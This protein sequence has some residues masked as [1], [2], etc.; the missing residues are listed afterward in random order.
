VRP[1][2]S[3]LAARVAK[4]ETKPSLIQR[5]RN[6]E[7]NLQSSRLQSYSQVLNPL[8]IVGA[9]ICLDIKRELATAVLWLLKQRCDLRLVR[10]GVE[11]VAVVA[12]L[13][14]QVWQGDV[15][16][17]H[18][19]DTHG[20]CHVAGV[21]CNHRRVGDDECTLRIRVEGSRFL[22]QVEGTDSE[23]LQAIQAY[24]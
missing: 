7:V 19:T 22:E 14:R 4:K 9:C 20:S 10:C 18:T 5:R 21:Y 12:R 16:D 6:I 17:V 24:P 13:Q 11:G 8:P 1:L 23:T 3:L 2:I 15:C